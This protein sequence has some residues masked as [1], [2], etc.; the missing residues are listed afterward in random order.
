[1]SSSPNGLRAFLFDLDGTL[2]FNQPSG[3]E[4]FVQY[5]RDLGLT[6]NPEAVR[7]TER[8]QHE[9]WADR[10]TVDRL[11]AE[12]GED[13]GWLE[14]TRRQLA[15]L[16]ATGPIDDYAQAI[17]RRFLAEY[18]STSILGPDVI[19]TLATLRERGYVTGLVSNR[20][21]PL[22]PVAEEHGLVGLFD[23]TLS[24]GEAQ[25]WKPDPA[26]FHRALQLA[27]VAARC[28]V[29]VGDNYYADVIGAQNAG[30]LPILFD[31]NGL[32]PEAACRVIGSI[33]ELLEL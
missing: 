10:P 31:P 7:R 13:G 16:G 25:S 11:F 22:G 30:L 33:A 20:D 15:L 8:W 9:F 18:Q 2:R 23:F 29:Y 21:D 4:T 26:I 24:A 5:G 17:Q 1:M 19:G 27:G 3:Y 14:I 6:F 32:F 12:L 28:A